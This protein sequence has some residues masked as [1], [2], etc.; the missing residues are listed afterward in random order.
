MPLT[1]RQRLIYDQITTQQ[2]QKGYP[3]TVREIADALG[4]R[5]PN[6]VVC[7]LQ[8]LKRKGWVT[9]E[10]NHARTLRPLEVHDG[11]QQ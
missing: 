10:K 11:Q 4:I 9:W 7:H 6:G 3:A 2:A 8:V 5:S 1:K